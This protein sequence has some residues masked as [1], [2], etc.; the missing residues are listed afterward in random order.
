[1]QCLLAFGHG[2]LDQK[3]RELT[4]KIAKDSGNPEL[5]LARAVLHQS[6][7]DPKAALADY[8]SATECTPSHPP[9][10]LQLTRFQRKQGSRKE[11]LASIEKYFAILGATAPAPD[12]FRERALL[13]TPQAAMKDWSRYLEISEAISMTDFEKA[14]RSAMSAKQPEVARGFLLEGLQVYP[15]SISLHHLYCRLALL[16]KDQ[17]TARASFKTLELLY[18]GLLVK[19]RYQESEIWS[20]FNFPVPAKNARRS[21]LDAFR[22]LPPR[23]QKTRDLRAIATKIE[24]A[25]A[26]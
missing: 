2:E 18:P 5:F 1:M 7:R 17:K 24:S 13:E 20:D 15:K 22:K 16:K 4:E 14:T 26:Q 8:L 21:A 10:F 11:A 19:L 3:I 12:A 9:A 25:L 23:L 6:H